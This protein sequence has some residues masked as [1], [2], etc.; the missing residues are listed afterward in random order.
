MSTITRQAGQ[1]DAVIRYQSE[2]TQQLAIWVGKQRYDFTLPA[3]GAFVEPL[4]IH[5]GQLNLSDSG[6]TPIRMEVTAKGTMDF[7]GFELY[8]ANFFAAA[9]DE[10][11]ANQPAL[12]T[13]FPIARAAHSRIDKGQHPQAHFADKVL[14]GDSETRWQ[15]HPRQ[16]RQRWFE[17]D[18]GEAV[19]IKSIRTEIT[20]LKRHGNVLDDLMMTVRYQDEQGEWQ[21]LTSLPASKANEGFTVEQ[22]ARNW[23]FE[24]SS[25]G[26]I[27]SVRQVEMT[28]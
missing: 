17:I 7:H 9:Q 13:Q 4:D 14:D 3:T 12:V 21:T 25:K 2:Q 22:K 28:Q 18:H 20:A 27:F 23:R 16:S 10:G 6:A 5:L 1:F 26:P 8:E 15:P 24:F 11:Q 19:D